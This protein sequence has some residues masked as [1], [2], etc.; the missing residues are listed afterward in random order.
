MEAEIA[1]ETLEDYT[2]MVQLIYSYHCI[3]FPRELDSHTPYKLIFF[4]CYIQHNSDTI[5]PRLSRLFNIEYCS[6]WIG[7]GISI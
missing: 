2:T 4:Q 6:N 7:L 3:Q 5:K 1:S